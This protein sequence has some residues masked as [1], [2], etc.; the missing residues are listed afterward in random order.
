MHWRHSTF[1]GTLASLAVAAALLPAATA[2]ATPSFD[3]SRARGKAQQLVCTDAQLATLDRETARLYALAS[4]SP[5]LDTRQRA[6]LRAEQIG[7]IRGRDDCW[8][9][10]DLR[11]CVL[12][13]YVMRIHE[14]RRDYPDARADAPDSLSSGPVALACKGVD[15]PLAATF[16]RTAPPLACLASQGVFYTLAL[17][18]AA[19]GARYVT[20]TETGD[21]LLWTRGDEA[22]VE[23]P[24]QPAMNC[25]L[26]RN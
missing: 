1:K 10:D 24:G 8:K 13:N 9:A 26:E 22:V 6:R 25:N 20:H 4:K 17:T 16:I 19:S 12:G 15:A 18:P 21:I 2:A 5:Q 14:L 11:A 7:W 3:C 23:I